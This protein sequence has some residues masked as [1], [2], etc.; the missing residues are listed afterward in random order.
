MALTKVQVGIENNQKN[1]K[2][3]MHPYLLVAKV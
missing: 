3:K 1:Q 2:K